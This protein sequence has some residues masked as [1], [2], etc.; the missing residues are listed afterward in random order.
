MSYLVPD[1][2]YPTPELNHVKR[3]PY[4]DFPIIWN[5]TQAKA[6]FYVDGDFLWVC[7][8]PAATLFKW[9]G[10]TW[11]EVSSYSNPDI[12]SGR[13]F[14][15]VTCTVDAYCTISELRQ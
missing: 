8:D 4:I 2:R 11:V 9:C 1:F 14:F 15:S 6:A 10:N 3:V 5:S 12:I 7:S 13:G